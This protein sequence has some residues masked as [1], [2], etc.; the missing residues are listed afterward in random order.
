MKDFDVKKYIENIINQTQAEEKLRR[1]EEKKKDR[2]QKL[3]KIKL[4]I[5]TGF[6]LIYRIL[7]FIVIGILIVFGILWAL[8]SG[9]AM[10]PFSSW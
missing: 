2:K 3:W 5:I 6:Y 8:N 9:P 7:K 4:N 10:G 1:I